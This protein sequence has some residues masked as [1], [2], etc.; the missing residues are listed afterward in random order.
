MKFN[1]SET[2]I[3]NQIST[4]GELIIDIKNEPKFFAKVEKMIAKFPDGFNFEFGNSGL[5]YISLA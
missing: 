4:S 5:L 1:K 2:H 3:V